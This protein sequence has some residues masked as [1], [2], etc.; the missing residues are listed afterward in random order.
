MQVIEKP[1][2]LGVIQAEGV[3]LK[4]RGR[5]WWGLCS[6]HSEKTPSFCVDPEKQSFKCY[7]CGKYGDA[8]D[9][10][11][12]Y[13]NLSFKDTLVYLGI[14]SNGQAKTN[15]PETRRREL[16]EKFK[17]WC[18]NYTKYLCERLRVCNQI[19]SLV[20]TSD[21]LELKGLS[22]IY[23][24]RDVCQYH[25]SILNGKDDKTKFELYKE[26]YYGKRI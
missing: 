16:I 6:F 7:G 19:D 25:L 13:K 21:D 11:Q 17:E 26:V 15:P 14:S 1:S 3:E 4:Q 2:I 10:V 22:E 23:L 24:L 12:H 9:F 20:K 18:C 8:I 5:L